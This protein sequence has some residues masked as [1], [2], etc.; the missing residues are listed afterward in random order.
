MSPCSGC[1]ALWTPTSSS[2]DVPKIIA[3]FAS[4]QSSAGQILGGMSSIVQVVHQEEL[5]DQFSSVGDFSWLDAAN[6]LKG[7]Q[8]PDMDANQDV[9]M[10]DRSPSQIFN[11][12]DLRPYRQ[13]ISQT[14]EM[15]K[16]MIGRPIPSRS[17]SSQDMSQ[18]NQVSHDVS[19]GEDELMEEAQPR[20]SLTEQQIETLEKVVKSSDWS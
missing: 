1:K 3:V 19:M 7:E 5:I 11:A 8:L 16:E 17:A 12:L 14:H 18:P 15:L 6:Q 4:P 13:H 2:F 9:P 20:I 10:L